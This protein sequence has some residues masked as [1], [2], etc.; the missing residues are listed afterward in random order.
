MKKHKRVSRAVL[1]SLVGLVGVSSLQAYAGSIVINLPPQP[2][3]QPQP[4]K[5]VIEIKKLR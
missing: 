5:S 1:L 4:K 2:K 3:P